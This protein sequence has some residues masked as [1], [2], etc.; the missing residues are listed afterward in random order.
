MNK[1]QK[2]AEY[3]TGHPVSCHTGYSVSGFQISL[4]SGTGTSADLT[5]YVQ[6]VLSNMLSTSVCQKEFTFLRKVSVVSVVCALG[7][8]VEFFFD[9]TEQVK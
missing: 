5:K 1:V 3:L 6:I 2:I 9:R 4:I 7:W 8:S